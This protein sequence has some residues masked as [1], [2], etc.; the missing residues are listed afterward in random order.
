MVPDSDCLW[1]QRLYN[2]ANTSSPSPEAVER[3]RKWTHPCLLTLE[4]EDLGVAF[5]MILDSNRQ[6]RVV[7]TAV[8]YGLGLPDAS[9]R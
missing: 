4:H 6:Q 9:Q 2:V 8:Q 5:A 7:G 3:Q 1:F